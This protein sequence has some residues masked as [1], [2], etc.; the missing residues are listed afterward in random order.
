M[1][2]TFS[3]SNT[4]NFGDLQAKVSELIRKGLAA[5][6]DFTVEFSSKQPKTSDQLRG[7]Y[8]LFQ[9][10]LP[11]FQAWKPQI[12]WD[13]EMIKEFTKTELGYVRE[14]NQFEIAMMIKQS[15]F[16]PTQEEKRRMVKFCKNIKQ[17]ISFADFTKEQLYNFTK[18]LEV[19]AL[20]QT[21][22]KP[23]WTDVFLSD[24]E[25]EALVE[26]FNKIK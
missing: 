20:T 1:K 11:H 9:L 22:E 21:P 19:W 25:K 10:A 7:A 24:G 2:L 8:K 17:N 5:K 23:A 18:E 16:K 4:A 15:G 13:L 6:K 26:Y 12:N 3:F 14:P